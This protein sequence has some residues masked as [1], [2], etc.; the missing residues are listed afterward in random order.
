MDSINKTTGMEDMRVK[1][2]I[3]WIFVMFN[4]LYADIVT[5]MDPV[6]LKETNDR[7]R[8]VSSNH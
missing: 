6:V 7:I 2:S 8:R 5:L 4:Y 3:L 1:L